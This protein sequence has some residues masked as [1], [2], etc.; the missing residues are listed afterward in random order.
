[1]NLLRGPLLLFRAP[2]SPTFLRSTVPLIFTKIFVGRLLLKVRALCVGVV[3]LVVD[4]DTLSIADD[5]FS[6]V[7]NFTRCG[8]CYLRFV[9]FARKF[10]E[11]Y[12]HL[13]SISGNIFITSHHTL[14]HAAFGFQL[15]FFRFDDLRFVVGMLISFHQR[16]R[17]ITP[18]DRN[19]TD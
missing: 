3:V 13:T 9:S 8:C 1:M 15:L 12:S 5:F 17:C 7:G 11:I 6:Y 4:L 2:R 19:K 18:R 10:L 16:N 14:F